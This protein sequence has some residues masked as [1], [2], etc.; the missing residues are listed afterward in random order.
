MF[1]PKCENLNLNTSWFSLIII[2]TWSKYAALHSTWEIWPLYMYNLVRKFLVLLAQPWVTQQGIFQSELQRDESAAF[3]FL[4]YAL[5]PCFY[6]AVMNEMEMSCIFAG[7]R[8]HLWP[9]PCT[10]ISCIFLPKKKKKWAARWCLLYKQLSADPASCPKT[11]EPWTH[12]ITDAIAPHCLSLVLF[13]RDRQKQTY[14]VTLRRR[15]RC[16]DLM[17]WNVHFTS[18]ENAG[19]YQSE[20]T[21]KPSNKD[22]I[23]S[24]WSHTER[25]KS[26]RQMATR[27]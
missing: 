12:L 25:E 17:Y 20:K 4:L 19:Q 11:K 5:F 15:H 8:I 24:V 9:C 2:T 7:D 3:P 27:H 1:N 21:D 26:Q 23:C 22:S 13:A 16:R 10:W 14:L 18:T 6:V